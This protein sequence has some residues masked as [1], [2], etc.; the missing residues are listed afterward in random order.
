MEE[1]KEEE[2]HE[3]EEKVRP[4]IEIDGEIFFEISSS[5]DPFSSG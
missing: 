5:N 1:Q 3:P 4:Y 2:K